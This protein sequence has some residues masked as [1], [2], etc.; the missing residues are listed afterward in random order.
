MNILK[1]LKN[2]KTPMRRKLLIYMLALAIIVLVFFGL[3]S[4]LFRAFRNGKTKGGSRPFVSDA[5][6]RTPGIK[7]L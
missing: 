7:V 3:R 2:R 5:N 6:L 4:I 1:S